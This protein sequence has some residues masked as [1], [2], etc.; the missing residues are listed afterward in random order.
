MTPHRNNRSR[1]C[2]TI[3]V[4]H[5]AHPLRTARLDFFGSVT[6]VVGIGLITKLIQALLAH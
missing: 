6:L 2:H 5:S 4:T 1:F 3:T